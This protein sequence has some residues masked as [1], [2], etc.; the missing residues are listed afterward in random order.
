MKPGEG[1]EVLEKG[2]KVLE[3]GARALERGVMCEIHTTKNIRHDQ[4]LISYG[5]SESGDV[6]QDPGSWITSTQTPD[7]W[8]ER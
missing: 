7:E 1:G 2:A 3:K 8:N 5:C 4:A 6:R